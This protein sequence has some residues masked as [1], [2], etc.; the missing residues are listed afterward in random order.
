ML[1]LK[2][3]LICGTTK[4]EQYYQQIKKI[5]IHHCSFF[6]QYFPLCGSFTSWI[7]H[8]ALRRQIPPETCALASERKEKNNRCKRAISMRG[9]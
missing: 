2:G 8:R 1:S 3:A 4:E 5:I 6:M 7:H 9:G